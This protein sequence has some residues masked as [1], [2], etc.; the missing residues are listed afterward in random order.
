M[1]PEVAAALISDYAITEAM[2]VFGGGFVS[3][4]GRLFRAA[5]ADNRATLK[6][7]FPEYWAEYRAIAARHPPT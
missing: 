5:D 4:L 3:G 6:A 7:A 2:I 1:D